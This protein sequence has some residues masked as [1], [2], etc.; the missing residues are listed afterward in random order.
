MIRYFCCRLTPSG[1]GDQLSQ[2]NRLHDLGRRWGLE[3]LY[4]DLPRNRW[5]P[6]FDAADF[7]GLGLGEQR[8]EG[9]PDHALV[10]IDG[11]EALR[12]LQEGRPLESLLPARV[13]PR[14]IIELVHSST[15]YSLGTPVQLRYPIKLREKLLQRHGAQILQRRR[16]D[17]LSVC[18][19][20]RQGDCTWVR[21]GDK[22]VFLGMRKI[23]S[24]PQDVDLRRAPHAEDYVPVLDDVAE[25]L[26]GRPW[27]LTAFSD[28]PTNI[29]PHPSRLRGQLLYRLALHEPR[30]IDWLQLARSRHPLHGF[31][32]P[33][34]DDV[35][36]RAYEHARDAVH[37]LEARYPDVRLVVGTNRA[38]TEEAI[39]AFATADVAV[40]AR[41]RMA[42]PLLGLG[43]PEIQA[44]LLLTKDRVENQ[45]SLEELLSRLRPLHP[46]TPVS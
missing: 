13:P 34:C 11:A 10:S 1:I 33:M 30:I 9:I 2:L 24:D 36:V 40:L 37:R 25:R 26:R 20:V 5:S 39:I 46:M 4:R 21:R 7:L 44:V 29:F 17:R 38:L 3:Y 8:L 14:P 32:N 35:V 42:F 41:S 45:A 27:S 18:V 15:M 28:G 12:A 6:D 23:A 19:H 16:P 31:Y 22:Y 43:D